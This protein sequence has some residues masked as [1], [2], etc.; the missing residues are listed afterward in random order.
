M[1]IFTPNTVI[2]SADV[3]LNFENLANGSAIMTGAITSAKLAP[4]KTTDANNWVVYDFGTI[5]RYVKRFYTG[6]INVA[7]GAR[8]AVSSNSGPVGVT[9]GATT[10]AFIV[11][12]SGNYGGH[13]VP[14]LENITAT[15]FDLYI[16]NQ[17]TGGTL[18][19][20]G[21]WY[22]ALEVF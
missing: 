16:G 1:I 18:T 4:S 8:T 22:V 15:T 6:G 5:K 11:S 9:M 17:Y 20:T 13:A 19:F 10:H 14:G 21:S 3:N 2:K 12:W 7:P